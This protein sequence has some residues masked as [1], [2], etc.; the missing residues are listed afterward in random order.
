MPGTNV[1]PSNDPSPDAALGSGSESD[2]GTGSGS[3]SHDPCDPSTAPADLAFVQTRV[4]TPSCALSHCHDAGAAAGLDL[5]AG[6][7]RDSLVAMVSTTQTGWV[8]VVPGDPAAS[9]L[10]VAVGG[11][12]G[13]LPE[14][15]MMPLGAPALCAGKV[16]AIIRWIMAG[17]GT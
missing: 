11:E 8:R 17:A 16:A 3:G 15:G 14:D 6:F 5:R 12:P 9:Y 4:F 10:A 1:S 2:A 7:A 13:P